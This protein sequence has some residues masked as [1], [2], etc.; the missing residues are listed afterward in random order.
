MKR[1]AFLLA[2]LAVPAVAGLRPV[3]IDDLMKLR[4]IVDV[5]IA[6]D[7]EQV[8]YVVSTP[9]VEKNEHQVALYLIS[10]KGGTPK[11]LAESLRILNAPLPSP[12]LRWK[13]DG[14]AVS[15][16]AIGGERP[17]VFA[18]PLSGDAPEQITKSP[19]GVFAYDWSPDGK[20]LAFLTRESPTPEEAKRRAMVNRVH[21]PDKP[22]RL[23][24]QPLGG[25]LRFVSSP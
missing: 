5:K 17:Q 7:G 11:R 18:I 14:S 19:E 6:P 2:L 16:L 22:A 21:L 25:E 10:A 15:V 20:S 12:R 24:V 8:A 23:A 4:S 3:T 9:S 1:I 13:P